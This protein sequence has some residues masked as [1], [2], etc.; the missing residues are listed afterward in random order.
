MAAVE[1]RPPAAKRRSIR[2]RLASRRGA[3][4]APVSRLP[5]PPLPASPL[6]AEPLPAGTAPAAQPFVGVE[7]LRARWAAAFSA[8][9]AALNSGRLYLRR[10]EIAARRKRL[11]E[12]RQSVDRLLQQLAREQHVLAEYVQLTITPGEAR[13]LLALPAGVQACVF[14]LDGVLIG[15]AA[16]HVEAWRETF[17]ELISRLAER[18]RGRFEQFDLRPFDP[19]LD[20]LAHIHGRPRLDG[21]RS[22]LEARGISLPEGRA[23]DPPGAETVHGLANRKNEALLRRL[24]EHGLSAYAGSRRYLALA[25]DAG[26]RC[27]VVSASANARTILD[28]SG[29]AELVDACVDGDTITLERLRPRPAPDILLSACHKLGV[30]P[31]HAVVFETTPAGLVAARAAGFRQVVAVDRLGE[32]KALRGQDPDLVISGLPDVLDRRL[33]S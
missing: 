9:E 24:N 27:A 3:A 8:A 20:Y 11:E 10:D 7:T 26:V 17:D 15:S 1:R 29:L 18:T 14:N 31:E 19:R 21:V 16:L 6:P 2:H 23:D 30:E 33:A 4:L 5:A 13:R 32:T 12:E 22:F 25:R 28:R